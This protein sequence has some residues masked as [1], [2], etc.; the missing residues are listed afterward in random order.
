MYQSV[1]AKSTN[2]NTNKQKESSKAKLPVQHFVLCLL[3]SDAAVDILNQ[4]TGNDFLS[5]LSNK[6][7]VA[8]D[9]DMDISS[10]KY[11]IVCKRDVHMQAHKMNKFCFNVQKC[12][13]FLLCFK[14]IGISIFNISR[15]P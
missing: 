3:F 2:R 8:C 14:N 9:V 13:N 6:F 11:E 1:N 4:D 15:R 5:L 7:E 10:V 12:K